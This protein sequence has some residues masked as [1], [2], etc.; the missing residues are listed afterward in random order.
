MTSDALNPGLQTL[1]KACGQ[2]TTTQVHELAD[3]AQVANLTSQAHALLAQDYPQYAPDEDQAAW[4]AAYEAPPS[5][6]RQLLT[7]ITDTAGKVVAFTSSQI[8]PALDTNSPGR[9]ALI[10]YTCA[11]W[12]YIISKVDF[13]RGN[14][15]NAAGAR[16]DNRSLAY[17]GALSLAK[18][19]AIQN[20]TTQGQIG[21]IVQEHKPE[22]D[23]KEWAAKMAGQVQLPITYMMPQWG[24]APENTSADAWVV[25][26]G[27]NGKPLGANLMEFVTAYIH[28]EGYYSETPAADKAFQ[29]MQA[30]TRRLGADYTTRSRAATPAGAAAKLTAAA[31]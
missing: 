16:G 23:E 24:A 9:Q 14:N 22:H 20:I 7:V 6:T 11:N 27:A 15:G 28:K 17:G 26:V 30:E 3:P 29:N 12:D 13:P 10:G 8:Y 19:Q 21:V 4:I 25:E 31:G 18:I 5:E 2:L 1:T